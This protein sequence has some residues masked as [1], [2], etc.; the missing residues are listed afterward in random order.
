MSRDVSGPLSYWL[1]SLVCIVNLSHVQLRLFI[2]ALSTER[3][4]V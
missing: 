1:Q 4:S 3:L 2:I